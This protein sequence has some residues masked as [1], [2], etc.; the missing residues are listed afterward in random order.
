MQLQ[1]RPYPGMS[2]RLQGPEKPSRHGG[3]L[4]GKIIAGPKCAKV[5]LQGT[6]DSL[7][8][9]CILQYSHGDE[10]PLFSS[11]CGPLMF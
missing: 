11:S 10:H 2:K 4:L 9:R 7:F 5:L 6:V 8:A 3:E 1:M